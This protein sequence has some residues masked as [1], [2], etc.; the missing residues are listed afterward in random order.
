LSPLF[1]EKE[2]KKRASADKPAETFLSRASMNEDGTGLKKSGMAAGKTS[3]G[4]A[5]KKSKA[6]GK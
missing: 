6:G 2:G 5:V 1:F 4:K 3:N